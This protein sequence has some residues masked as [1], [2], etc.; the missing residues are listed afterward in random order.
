MPPPMMA[1]RPQVGERA[2]AAPGADDRATG[3]EE[4]T[5]GWPHPAALLLDLVHRTAGP[6]GFFEI[7]DEALEHPQ[8]WRA[9]HGLPP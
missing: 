5:P 3:F 1:M 8:E 2:D 7:L 4:V 6:F 9:R